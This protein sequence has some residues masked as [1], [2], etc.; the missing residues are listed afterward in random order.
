MIDLKGK[1][2][3]VPGGSGGI[4]SA[5][6]RVLAACGADIIV[7]YHSNKDLAMRIVEEVKQCGQR[8]RADMV[9]ATNRDEVKRWVDLTALEYG[10]I[11]ILANC[12][13]WHGHFQLL[14]DQSPEEWLRIINI[15]LMAA[16]YF[17]YSVLDHM[18]SRGAGRIITLSSD[19]AKAGETG[20][21]ISSAARGGVNAFSRTLARELA[22]HGITVNTVCPGPVNTPALSQMQADAGAGAKIVAALVRHIPMKRVADPQEVANVVAFL[23]SDEASFITGQAISVS[24]GLTMY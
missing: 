11:D 6:A 9:D 17:A 15:E 7:G 21:A 10:H 20:A 23:A 19:S 14:K 5:V 1:V 3:L 24:G 16:I 12:V 8:A 2:A 18:V 13:G 4:G 22:P